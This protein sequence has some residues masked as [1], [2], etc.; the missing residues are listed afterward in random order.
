MQQQASS[1]RI[2]SCLTSYD[3]V[4][5]SIKWISKHVPAPKYVEYAW[6]LCWILYR[7]VLLQSLYH[8][9]LLGTSAKVAKA[10]GV[11]ERC[12]AGPEIVADA[13]GDVPKPSTVILACSDSRVPPEIICDQGLGDCH[14]VR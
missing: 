8:E 4:V 14:V 1:A 10:Q 6:C 5:S 11:L 3:F 7:T 2:S 12:K 13:A 9:S